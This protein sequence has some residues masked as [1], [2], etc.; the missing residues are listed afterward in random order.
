MSELA[1]MSEQAC[2]VF[3]GQLR[4]DSFIEFAR[5]RAARLGLRIDV[6]QIS[7]QAVTVQA[8]TVNV[9]GAAELVDAF[10]MACS[11]GPYDCLVLEVARHDRK[12]AA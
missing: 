12:C 7:D 4:T 10:E 8:V 1:T 11:L 2:F 3:T 5:H 6:G 9:S